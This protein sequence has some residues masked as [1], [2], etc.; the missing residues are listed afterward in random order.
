MVWLARMLK[1]KQSLVDFDVTCHYPDEVEGHD[2]MTLT[3]QD[4][5]CRKSYVY[6][7]AASTPAV[8]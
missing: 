7:A 6:T 4:L 1:S 2:L 5:K 3:E 8:Y